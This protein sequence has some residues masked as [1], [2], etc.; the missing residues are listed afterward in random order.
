[1]ITFKKFITDWNKDKEFHTTKGAGTWS[2]AKLAELDKHLSDP[3]KSLDHIADAM[4]TNVNNLRNIISYYKTTKLP[5]AKI[6]RKPIVDKRYKW[7]DSKIDTLNHHL[8]D[9]QSIIRLAN[10]MNEPEDSIRYAI[11]THTKRL[12]NYVP[13][14]GRSEPKVLTKDLINRFVKIKSVGMS[15]QEKAD[16]LGVKQHTVGV[17]NRFYSDTPQTSQKSKSVYKPE[18]DEHIA[19]LRAKGYG[20]KAITLSL[21]TEH[22]TNFTVKSVQHRINKLKL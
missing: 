10:L 8:K 19:K 1:M 21:S 13:G 18:H 16:Y 14:R 15:K 17:L 5:N 3:N 20:P 2:D 4:N 11:K 12:P 22:G 7:N 9:T 6:Q